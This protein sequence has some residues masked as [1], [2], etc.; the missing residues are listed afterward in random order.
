MCSGYVSSSASVRMSDGV[1]MFTARYSSSSP[2]LPYTSGMCLRSRPSSGPM[3]ARE[4]PTVFSK[5][6][7]WLS[8]MPMDVPPS[9][10]VRE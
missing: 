4:R 6:R 10:Q 9:R 8:W 5:K 1:A 7:L 2:T 3:N